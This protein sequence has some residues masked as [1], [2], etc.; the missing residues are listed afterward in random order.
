MQYLLQNKW[1]NSPTFLTNIS[2]YSERFHGYMYAEDMTFRKNHIFIIKHINM[3]ATTE[4]TQ[5][6]WKLNT[7]LH[8]LTVNQR[9]DA[10]VLLFFLNEYK[11]QDM[12]FKQLK[13]FW[14]DNIYKLP[15]TSSKEYGS[16]KTG[17]Y[18]ILS[19][20]KRIH[21]EYMVQLQLQE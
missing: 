15:E 3:I 4:H 1:E 17:R 21:R 8:N 7:D 6:T 13:S 18:N 2:P 9:R 12:A 20:M 16:I 10:L 11:E 14:I 19:R 5:K